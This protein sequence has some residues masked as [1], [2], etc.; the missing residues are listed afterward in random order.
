MK[1]PNKY[2]RNLKPYK[3]ASNKIWSVELEERPEILKLDW[4]EASISPSLTKQGQ[5]P[6]DYKLHYFNDNLEFVYC[7]VDRERIKKCNIYDSNWNLLYFTWLG[8]FKDP[9]AFRGLEIPTPKSFDKMKELAN[10]ITKD[11][12]Y[13]RVDFYDIDG[14]F[15]L[16]ENNFDHGSRFDIFHHQNM[17]EFTGKN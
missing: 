13:V 8:K 5:L 14:E 16:G 7:S 2:L 1:F 11:F 3:L 10:E 17:I 15:I 9:A 12:K 4:N 6:N